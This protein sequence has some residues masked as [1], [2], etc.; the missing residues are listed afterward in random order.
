[1]K[2]VRYFDSL[3]FFAIFIVFVTHFIADYHEEYFYLWT[4]FPTSLLLDGISGKLGVALFGVILGYFA[5][6]SKEENGTAYILKRFSFFVI[7]GLII[8]SLYALVGV[9]LD[10]FPRYSVLRVLFESLTLNDNIFPTYWCIPAFFAA[11]VISYLNG[12]AQIKTFGILLEIAVF[13]KLGCIWIAICLM[14]NLVARY[15]NNPSP[16]ILKTRI[17]RV[18]LWIVLFFAVKRPEN[19]ITDMINGVC[20]MVRVMLIMRGSI[21]QRVLDNRV[22]SALGQRSM[23]IYILHPLCYSVMA[24]TLFKLFSFMQYDLRFAVTMLICF[25]AIVLA[26]FPTMVFINMACRYVG[27]GILRVLHGLE[28]NCS[29]SKR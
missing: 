7:G 24:P 20:C 21:V 5:Y 2:R 27:K 9:F 28:M 22:L 25:G 10:G 26:S 29:I 8:N 16:D 1:M 4:T 23:A 17:I 14:G 11:S 12:K 6:L 19:N 3:R 15:Q 18:I 13:Y